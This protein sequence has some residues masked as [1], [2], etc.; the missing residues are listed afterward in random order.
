[1][2]LL[3]CISSH[4]VVIVFHAQKPTFKHTAS[5]K[6]PLRKGAFLVRTVVSMCTLVS[7]LAIYQQKFVITYEWFADDLVM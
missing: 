2:M 1:M 4:I 7:T 5:I 3:S 6:T